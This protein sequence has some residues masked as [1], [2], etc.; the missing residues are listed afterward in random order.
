MYTV[1]AGCVA[2]LMLAALAWVMIR[3]LPVAASVKAS[4]FR[5]PPPNDD[6]LDSFWSPLYRASHFI[7]KWTLFLGHVLVAVMLYWFMGP[8]VTAHV[9]VVFFE[10]LWILIATPLALSIYGQ[11][12]PIYAQ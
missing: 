9:A 7:S 3:E 1:F 6:Q 4:L 2:G 10:I 8:T 11:E 5:V 12:D